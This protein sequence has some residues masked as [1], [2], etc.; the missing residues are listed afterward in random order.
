MPR[1]ESKLQPS[2][3]VTLVRSLHFLCLFFHLIDGDGD[4]ASL[5]ELLESAGWSAL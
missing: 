4:C 5:V 3:C 2:Y 1:S